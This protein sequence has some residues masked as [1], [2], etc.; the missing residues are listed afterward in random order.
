M[1]KETKDQVRRL[2]PQR[3]DIVV[4]TPG[5]PISP[6]EAS[7]LHEQLQRALDR[8]GT[9]DVQP[10]VLPD[11]DAKIEVVAG[12]ELADAAATDS[13]LHERSAA[14]DTAQKSGARKKRKAIDEPAGE[15]LG[16]EGGVE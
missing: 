5:Q 8:S 10:V 14:I 3:G 11:P 15:G 12:Q 1:N 6:G 13:P 16:S 7:R 4:L 9:T 2:R